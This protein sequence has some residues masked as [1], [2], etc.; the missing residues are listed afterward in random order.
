MPLS[1]LVPDVSALL[2][3]V[4]DE[5]T[6]RLLTESR[7]SSG[8][9]PL[10]L[11]T[12]SHCPD[13]R[14]MH[15]GYKEFSSLVTRCQQRK[16]PYPGK[17]YLTVPRRTPEA[18]T[19]KQLEEQ[20]EC[21]FHPTIGKVSVAL[22]LARHDRQQ[23]P[24]R[25]PDLEYVK[26]MTARAVAKRKAK[27][28][29]TACAQVPTLVD[30]IS[31]DSFSNKSVEKEKEMVDPETKI[32]SSAPIRRSSAIG[33]ILKVE[34]QRTASKILTA[35]HE[36]L[37]AE[38]EAHPFRPTLIKPPKTVVPR[39]KTDRGTTK[40]MYQVVIPYTTPYLF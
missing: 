7:S 25:D 18:A 30:F 2:T 11:N 26:A 28:R 12:Y 29:V 22:S 15:V 16:G 3:Q 14:A 36:H 31:E 40:I 4:R 13:L 35:R 20:A 9:G 8:P 10:E 37:K 5:K 17:G 6:R 27:D 33:T 21:V 24:G 39:Y 1:S 19:K 32:P 38:K 23:Y 34:E